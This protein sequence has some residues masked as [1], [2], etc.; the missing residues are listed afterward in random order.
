MNDDEDYITSITSF[1]KEISEFL[2]E[3]K[4]RRGNLT[5]LYSEKGAQNCNSINCSRNNNRV[6]SS[7][8]NSSWPILCNKFIKQFRSFLSVSKTT[9]NVKNLRNCTYVHSSTLKDLGRGSRR[10]YRQ[11]PLRR[12]SP[13]LLFN[14]SKLRRHSQEASGHVHPKPSRAIHLL[15][16]SNLNHSAQTLLFRTCETFEPLSLAINVRNFHL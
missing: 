5:S 8:E 11:Y 4:Y 1:N 16:T 3:T 15:F 9:S 10:Y 2:K 6:G 7:R 13:S 14:P 12:L